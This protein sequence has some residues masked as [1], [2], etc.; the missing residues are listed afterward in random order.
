MSVHWGNSTSSTSPPP[1]KRP[2]RLEPGQ[3]HVGSE[4][5]AFLQQE[6]ASRAVLESGDAPVPVPTRTVAD[7]ERQTRIAGGVSLLKQAQLNALSTTT[8]GTY[9]KHMKRFCSWAEAYN[10][11]LNFVH[12]SKGGRSVP[13]D[14]FALYAGRHHQ[15]HDAE[16]LAGGAEPASLPE[17]KS[18][19]DGQSTSA[20]GRTVPTAYRVHKCGP[21]SRTCNWH[22]DNQSTMT[23]RE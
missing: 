1:R 7:I 10:M 19:L 3:M 11:Q 4:R 12:K 15:S 18:P 23:F 8:K 17:W 2:R 21:N 20:Y 13:D 5:A 6:A 22:L 16:L 9:K 14:V